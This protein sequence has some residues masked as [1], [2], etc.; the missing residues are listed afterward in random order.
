LQ[1]NCFETLLRSPLNETLIKSPISGQFYPGTCTSF[2][3]D[4]AA[5]V[6][7]A[8]LYDRTHA[9]SGTLIN[10]ALEAMMHRRILNTDAKGPLDLNDKGVG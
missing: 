10:G 7:L 8:L 3:R 6:E 2:I 5:D 9:V 4:S 1:D